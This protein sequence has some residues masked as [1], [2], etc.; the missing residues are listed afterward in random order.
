MSLGYRAG[1]RGIVS[2]TGKR[3]VPCLPKPYTFPFNWPGN[4]RSPTPQT[5]VGRSRAGR[6]AN[7]PA[8]YSRP[9]KSVPSTRR[10]MGGSDG[11]ICE[12][13]RGRDNAWR[14]GLEKSARR[15]IPSPFARSEADGLP[16]NRAVPAMTGWVADWPPIARTEHGTMRVTGSGRMVFSLGDSL[17]YPLVDGVARAPS[18]ASLHVG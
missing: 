1:A 11:S 9:K 6:S 7:G 18:G 13:L 10:H 12:R 16:L 5:K 8:G 14:G 15:I 2:R 4:E 17:A 3:P